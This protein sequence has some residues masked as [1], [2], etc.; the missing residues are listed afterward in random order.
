MICWRRGCQARQPELAAELAGGFGQCHAVAAFGGNAGRF[1]ARYAAAD[2]QHMLWLRGGVETVAAPFEFAA[3]AR[4]DEAGDPVVAR[5]S[6]PAH[7]VAGE[8]RADVLGPAFACL[9]GEMRIGN[10][11]TDD[12]HHVGLARR[13]DIIGVLG[14]ADMRLALHLGV[15]H[16]LFQCLGMR[17]AE[18]VG[19]EDIGNDAGDVEIAAGAA[20]DVVHQLALVMPGDDLLQLLDGLR[21]LR[22]RGPC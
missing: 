5:P 20:G 15:R 12:R 3:G 11:S 17:R 19:K 1:K 7:L 14:R 13:H 16:H 9:V 10:L 22:R 8:A 21:D 4:V 18:L 6:A 2:D